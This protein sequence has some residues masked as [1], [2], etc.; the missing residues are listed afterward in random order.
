MNP[1]LD[2]GLTRIQPSSAALD[3]PYGLKESQTAGP[4]PKLGCKCRR[5]QPSNRCENADQ[6]LLHVMPDPRSAEGL[7]RTYQSLLRRTPNSD[8]EKQI[9]NDVRRTYPELGIFQ[10]GG[11]DA[12]MLHRILSAFS[13]RE[14][15]LGYVQGMNFVVASLLY[16]LQDESLTFWVFCHLVQWLD[17]KENYKKGR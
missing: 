1:L 10:K 17:L 6:W 14:P 11:P 3:Q 12:E 4:L 5:V 2:T 13:I 7:H 15:E 8:D 9:A 16:H